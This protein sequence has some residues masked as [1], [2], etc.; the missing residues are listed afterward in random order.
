MHANNHNNNKGQSK[1]GRTGGIPNCRKPLFIDVVSKHLPLGRD[2]WLAV[3]AS[4]WTRSEELEPREVELMKR[5][6]FDR[7]LMK[8]I[9]PTGDSA[10][11]AQVRLAQ[12]V[13]QG[14]HRRA[15]ITTYG[16]DDSEEDSG[17]GNEQQALDAV[18]E[19]AL[20]LKSWGTI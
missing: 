3:Q 14:I 18:A 4:Y 9:K 20:Q 19:E 5:Y 8:G 17:S 11:A 16:G 13:A 12:N 2:G 15:A 1:G 10:P 7:C 6:W